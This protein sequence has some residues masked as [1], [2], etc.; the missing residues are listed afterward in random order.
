MGHCRG[1]GSVPSLV[2]SVCLRCSLKKKKKKNQ[3]SCTF[4]YLNSLF[5]ISSRLIDL[6]TIYMSLTPNSYFHFRYFSPNSDFYIQFIVSQFYFTIYYKSQITHI[7]D[8]RPDFPSAVFILTTFPISVEDSASF[9]FKPKSLES[10]MTPHIPFSAH[11]FSC[12][13]PHLIPIHQNIFLVY[14]QNT[15]NI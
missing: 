4:H 3:N 13:F 6:K 7:E 12:H 15:S 1:A 11:L 8:L 2:T 10:A 5:V 9:Q 14:L